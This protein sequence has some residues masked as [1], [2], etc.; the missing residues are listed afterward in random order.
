MIL[1]G[2]IKTQAQREIICNFRY[3]ECIIRV[4]SRQKSLSHISMT[5]DAK[6]LDFSSQEKVFLTSVMGPETN[7]SSVHVSFLI[8]LSKNV[9]QI[10]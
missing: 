9:K 8:L 5:Y 6:L 3:R 4:S 10:K 2:K 7:R 1:N